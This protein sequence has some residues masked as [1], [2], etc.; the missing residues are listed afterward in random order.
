MPLR[1]KRMGGGASDNAGS[2]DDDLHGHL[3][4]LATALLILRSCRPGADLSSHDAAGRHPFGVKFIATPLM[5]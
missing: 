5:Q 4:R 3:I 1:E 2:D